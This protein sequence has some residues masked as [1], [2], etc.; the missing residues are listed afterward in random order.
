MDYKDTLEQ[1]KTQHQSYATYCDPE[2]AHALEN[3]VTAL[4]I[5]IKE[6]DAAVSALHGNC[7]VCKHNKGWHNVGKCRTCKHENAST[8]LPDDTLTHTDDNW[9]WKGP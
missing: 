8:F 2:L 1:I 9:T 7:H 5:L 3:A 4:E 6:R